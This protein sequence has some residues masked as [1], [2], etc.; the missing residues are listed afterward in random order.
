VLAVGSNSSET[1]SDCDAQTQP[2]GIFALQSVRI[3]SQ[4]TTQGTLCLY[5]CACVCLYVCV[6]ACMGVCERVNVCG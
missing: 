4:T 6:R 1:Y 2:E 3:S 5:I